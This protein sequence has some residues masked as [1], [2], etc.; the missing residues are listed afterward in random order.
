MGRA[1]GSCD[2]SGVASLRDA[3]PIHRMCKSEIITVIN[4]S[5]PCVLYYIFLI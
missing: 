3:G 5:T 4:V 2:L 1:E